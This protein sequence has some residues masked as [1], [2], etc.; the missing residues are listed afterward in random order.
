LNKKGL[1]AANVYIDSI[2]ILAF[3]LLATLF[4]VLFSLQGKTTEVSIEGKADEVTSNILLLNYLRTPVEVNNKEMSMSELIALWYW[5]NDKYDE[6]LKN[7]SKTILDFAS[8][9]Y[10]KEVAFSDVVLISSYKIL[11]GDEFYVN[12]PSYVESS[13][14]TRSGINCDDVAESYVPVSKNEIVKITLRK[15]GVRR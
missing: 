12:T 11:I 8:Y 6:L 5:D 9:D 15:E 1:W 2:S 3:V 14:C 7:E 10:V 13:D 4:F